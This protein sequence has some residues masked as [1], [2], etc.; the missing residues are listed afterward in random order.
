MTI[1]AVRKLCAG[2]KVPQ[3]PII[4]EIIDP[5]KVALATY[6]GGEEEG[7]VEVVSAQKFGERL[8][9]H[10]AANPGL[11]TLYERLLTFETDNSEI[12]SAML[13][14]EHEKLTFDD[15]I[16]RALDLRVDGTSILPIA[17]M[18]GPLSAGDTR[19]GIF[20]N[21][22]HVQIGNLRAKDTLFALCDNAT[23]LKKIL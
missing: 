19:G 6:A 13:S 21:P 18:R 3:V 16:R 8:L 1:M 20:V 17:I 10:A 7:L 5:Q 4:A 23:E 15:L 12:H 2:E 11:T 14:T 22:T 9:T